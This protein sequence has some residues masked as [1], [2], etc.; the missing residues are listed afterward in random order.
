[1]DDHKLSGL[2]PTNSGSTIRRRQAQKKENSWSADHLI[3]RC[4]RK[5]PKTFERCKDKVQ[6][7]I[8]YVHSSWWACFQNPAECISW[9][10]LDVTKQK[11]TYKHCPRLGSMLRSQ[12]SAIFANFRWKNAF[13]LKTNATHSYSLCKTSANLKTLIFSPYFSAKTFLK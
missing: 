6:T 2:E 13:F 4:N 9:A 3:L 12:F 11:G 8:M 5:R 1:L 10:S 7:N